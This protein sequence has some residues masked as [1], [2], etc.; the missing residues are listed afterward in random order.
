MKHRTAAKEKQQQPAT[1]RIPAFSSIEE[2][3]EFWDTHDSTEFEDEF[4]PVTDVK[5][6]FVPA[7]TQKGIMV[8]LDYDTILRITEMGRA[9]GVG[10][11]TLARMWVLEKLA[12]L[13]KDQPEVKNS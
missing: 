9:K 12:E 3:A 13:E 8:R 5:I 2:E 6:I 10:P 7:R 4:E 11:S 1:S